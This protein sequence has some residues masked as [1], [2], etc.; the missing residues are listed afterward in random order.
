MR[1]G[2]KFGKLSVKSLK[3]AQILMQRVEP[4]LLADVVYR[5]TWI[6]SPMQLGL[7]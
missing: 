6:A 4:S 2:T 3:L 5:Q 7:V 1:I